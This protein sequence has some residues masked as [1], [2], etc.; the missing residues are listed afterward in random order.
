MAEEEQNQRATVQSLVIMVEKAAAD[1]TKRTERAGGKQGEAD[2]HHSMLKRYLDSKILQN[3]WII[4]SRHT[5]WFVK[6][7][8]LLAESE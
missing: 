7:Q 5:G 2:I 1:S 4:L 8:M 6:A 3:P